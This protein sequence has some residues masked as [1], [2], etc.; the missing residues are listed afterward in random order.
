MKKAYRIE[1]DDWLSE[2]S[3]VTAFT[4][5]VLFLYIIFMIKYPV[6]AWLFAGGYLFLLIISRI[7][8][9]SYKVK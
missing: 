1:M 6:L 9:K 3:M 7:R 2:T 8:I 5:W 4:I